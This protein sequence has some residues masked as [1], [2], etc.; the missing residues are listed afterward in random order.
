MGDG[1]GPLPRH[2]LRTVSGMAFRCGAVS[3]Q[4]PFFFCTEIEAETV[5]VFSDNL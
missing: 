1:G 2:V 4:F 5:A 3:H